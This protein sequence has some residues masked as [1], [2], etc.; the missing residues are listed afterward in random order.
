[1]AFYQEFRYCHVQYIL[2]YGDGICD[3]YGEYNTLACNYDGG[4]CLKFN[5]EFPDCKANL[6]Q[7]LGNGHCDNYG[8]YNTETCGFDKGDCIKFNQE[9]PGCKATNGTHV[10]D[11]FCDSGEYNTE[12]CEFDGGDC[13]K[14]NEKYPNCEATWP[15]G[16]LLESQVIPQLGNEWCDFEFDELFYTEEC[17]W[18]DGDC[19]NPFYNLTE[20]ST[21]YP[22]C[23][24]IYPAYHLF[25]NGRCN[26][27]YNTP[28]CGFDGGDCNWFNE[29]FPNSEC[30]V[31]AP[32]KISEMP[33][34]PGGK[35]NGGVYNTPECK[36]DGGDC[37][38]F[39]IEYPN[40]TVENPS[41]VND[42]RCDGPK[43][44]TTEC[45]FDGGDCL[46][47]VLQNPD[48]PYCYVTEPEFFGDGK[49]DGGEYNI[50][51]CDFDGGD[52]DDFNSKYP[53]CDKSVNSSRFG[54]GNCDAE[55][56]SDDCGNDGGDC[57]QALL[58]IYGKRVEV[59]KYRSD[60]RTF[61]IIQ[62]SFSAISFIASIGI[63]CVIYRSYERFS[64][65][66]HRLLIGLS[67]S[68]MLSSF[69][70]IFATLPAPREFSDVIW[71]A[72]G[73]VESCEAQGF[74]IFVGSI[75]APLYNC[76]LCF[77][78]L[79]ILKYGKKDEWIK[80]KLEPYLHG[81]PL[82]VSL[83]GGFIILGKK[84][85]NP[86]MTYCYIGPDPECGSGICD[87]MVDSRFLFYLFSAAPYIILPC[88][89]VISMASIYQVVRTQEKKA[90]QFDWKA[91][92]KANAAAKDPKKKGKTNKRRN[93]RKNKQSRVVL[94]TA[95]SYS[96]AFLF[97]YMLP[98]VISIQT[99]QEVRSGMALSILAR[100]LFPLQGFFNFCVFM[101]PSVRA[102]KIRGKAENISWWTAFMM[103]L[104]SRG[105]RKKNRDLR[106]SMKKKKASK[107][108]LVLNRIL[109]IVSYASQAF[110]WTSSR[111]NTS[112]K[113]SSSYNPNSKSRSR[114]S[115]QAA[116]NDVSSKH[117]KDVEKN[118]NSTPSRDHKR[119]S[120]TF[121][122][123]PAA[124]SPFPIKSSQQ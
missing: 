24:L 62:S 15:L 74:F 70:Q 82:L 49:C 88:V 22:N 76:S 83:L 89:I 90:S 12:A 107:L 123:T 4:D 93:R 16:P 55:L 29:L 20:H 52:C 2:R 58:F 119:R 120:V 44:N 86:N 69:A 114:N 13:I 57:D 27:M 31:P 36:F 34:I 10:G 75:A 115:I 6:T 37:D 26:N 100:I 11:G 101:Y 106:S 1:M 111:R 108:S 104:K 71:N 41:W 14:F 3:N 43:Y 112:T 98:M 48:F 7:L 56:E 122:S 5:Q 92:L 21:K 38:I 60:T 91:K 59:D 19:A 35:C 113:S 124:L 33:W 77:Y 117:A 23:T 18:D 109:G 46:G 45:G 72:H 50:E 80:E 99:I 84:A 65:T 87:R 103:A 79:A 39:N 116:R 102:I 63:F 118:E 17:G 97:S 121:V 8:E 78:Y 85:F 32:E 51:E 110:S 54:D 61:S 95:A 30:K 25:K 47:V 28:E 66:I 53:K 81:V 42:N 105:A 40:C 67:V 96:L 73:T 68:D 94:N 9:Y 64:T